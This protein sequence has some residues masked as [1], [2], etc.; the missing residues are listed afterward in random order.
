[1]AQ[2]LPWSLRGV[3][4]A[5]RE[6]VKAAARRAGL[7][8]ADWLEQVSREEA[9]REAL[10]QALEAEAEP[11]RRNRAERFTRSG[12][13]AAIGRAG[14]PVSPRD[15][16]AVIAQAARIEARS[17]DAEAKTATALESIVDWIERAENRMVD[18]ERAAAAREEKT[19]SVIAEAIKAVSTRV[20]E[21]E[22]RA[23]DRRAEEPLRAAAGERLAAQ[24]RPQVRAAG[25]SRDNLAA[26]VSDIR[27]RQR[28]LDRG[29]PRPQQG[30]A[31]ILPFGERRIGER[32]AEVTP[33]MNELRED[34]ARLREEIQALASRKPDTRLDEE[35]RE[36]ARKLDRR[37]G[38][39]IDDLARPLAR[40]E[41]E[42]TRLQDRGSD[43]RF[44]LIEREL[45]RLGDRIEQLAAGAQEPRLLSAAINEI[46]ALRSAVASVDP[47]P[48]MD[49][50]GQQI[51]RLADE[52]GRARDTGRQG[53]E[54]AV[55]DMRDALARDAREWSGVSQTLLQRIAMQ[56]ETVADAVGALPQGRLDDGDRQEIASLS[57]KLDQLA[58]RAEPESDE[59]A[60]RIETLAMRLDDLARAGSQEVIERIE[61]LSA[62]VEQ[63]A[64]RGPS[65]IERQIDQLAARIET[66]A[67]SRQLEALSGGGAIAPVDLSPI[68]A[69]IGDLARRLDEA[70]RPDSGAEHL[71]GLER[72]I[73]RLAE[74]LDE[75]TPAPSHAGLE[76]TLQDLMRS[77]GGLREETSSAV[78]RAARAA[79]ESVAMLHREPGLSASTVS[80][81]CART[82]PAFARS[83]SPST[84]APMKRWA[85]SATRSRAWCAGLPRSKARCRASASG[86]NQPRLA[87][88]PWP[89]STRRPRRAAS[90][91][92]SRRPCRRPNRCVRALRAVRRPRSQALRSLSAS[93]WLRRPPCA[94]RRP[95]SPLRRPIPPRT[96]RS[97]SARAV[98][99]AAPRRRRHPPRS[100]GPRSTPT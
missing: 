6:A 13:Q 38:E 88:S 1:M 15:I 22:R 58:M 41:A 68:E 45:Q 60:A 76:R 27:S 42:L 23:G 63:L 92:M 43:E 2:N 11:P 16:E 74:R 14:E 96:C 93:P 7:S 78:D 56:L 50:L 95:R 91:S 18:A 70:A 21:V 53:L 83:I 99:A 37:G 71:Q 100:I 34:M 19:A 64:S 80:R 5:V 49:E 87:T 12:S 48:R 44:G 98:P 28:D 36:L 81:P 30:S 24:A 66:I 29:T 4:P 84:G 89:S 25:L 65:S 9:R 72:Q 47:A 75:A 90:R 86:P 82:W 97:R 40:I 54:Q 57:R 17:R 79:A 32:R 55:S 31:P 8:V 67:G 52:L 73:A 35:I 39:G 33:Q 3:D 85:P 61:R 69:M 20:N 10:E 62:Q 26:V 94:P 59:L 46:T 77:L 51:A